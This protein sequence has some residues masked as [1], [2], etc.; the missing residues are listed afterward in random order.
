MAILPK[1]NFEAAFSRKNQL[2]FSKDVTNNSE[3]FLDGI[4]IQVTRSS[5]TPLT[6]VYGE[7][8]TTPKFQILKKVFELWVSFFQG[9][10]QEFKYAKI[11]GI[12]QSVGEL[13][14]F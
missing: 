4:N 8:F 12:S 7:F 1:R 9:H 2:R 11:F 6:W 3:I 14:A 5:L 13:L 10:Y